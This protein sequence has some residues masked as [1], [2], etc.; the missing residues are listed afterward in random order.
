[1]TIRRKK[2]NS[3]LDE[4]DEI[5]KSMC[6][7]CYNL[8]ELVIFMVPYVMSNG[9]RDKGFMRCPEC[10]NVVS[11]KQARYFSET[12]VLGR[13]GGISK[14]HFETVTKRRR[15][16]RNLQSE[17]PEF[18]PDDYKFSFGPDKDLEYWNNVG[19]VTSVTDSGIDSEESP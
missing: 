15:I 14:P 10:Q 17:G 7:A 19:V 6:S 18:N 16:D 12:G 11:I 1:M 5:E 9:K 13:E 3:Y 8:D 4:E 2:A